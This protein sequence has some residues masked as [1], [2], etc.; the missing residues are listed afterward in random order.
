VIGDYGVDH[1]TVFC[2]NAPIVAQSAVIIAARC[3]RAGSLH[4]IFY[5][6]AEFS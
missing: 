3:A 4:E 5:E 2:V 1:M 6:R